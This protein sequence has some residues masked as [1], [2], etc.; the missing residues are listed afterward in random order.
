RTQM[1][2]LTDPLMQGIEKGA[3]IKQ[4]E[5][6]NGSVEGHLLAK[7]WNGGRWWGI[8]VRRRRRLGWCRP[9]TRRDGRV[10]LRAIHSRAQEPSLWAAGV[11]TAA[12]Q[13]VFVGTRD[14]G[15]A[16][17]E[18]PRR[19]AGTVDRVDHEDAIGNREIPEPSS[20]LDD[21]RGR[22]RRGASVYDQPVRSGA[23]SC[24]NRVLQQTSGLAHIVTC[25]AE[26]VA[27]DR[28]AV[29]EVDGACIGDSRKQARREGHNRMVT[30]SGKHR[31]GGI[32]AKRSC[33][34]AG[35]AKPKRAIER[36]LR[37]ICELDRLPIYK[38]LNVVGD[39]VV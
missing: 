9:L 38:T 13:R 32:D 34:C 29:G 31:A 16:Q 6:R 22:T 36:E 17:C 11:D 4:G 5:R 2:L 26:A 35:I 7:V 15:S 23:V 25:D 10:R 20:V 19:R 30:L 8:R 27:W 39:C 33:S 28:T 3:A 14:N 21:K 1:L 24:E 18:C 37:G 12:K